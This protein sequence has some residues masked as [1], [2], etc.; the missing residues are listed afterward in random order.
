[1]TMAF[2]AAPN[3][4]GNAKNHKHYRMFV[5]SFRMFFK[6]NTVFLVMFSL[7]FESV[8]LFFDSNTLF[9]ELYFLSHGSNTLISYV[10]TT[11]PSIS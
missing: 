7:T 3:I 1:M 10:I 11:D 6:R 5:A 4:G 9:F 8:F 2:D